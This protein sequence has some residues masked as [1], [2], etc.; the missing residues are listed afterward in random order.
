MNALR[1]ASELKAL[2]TTKASGSSSG[3]SKPVLF[4]IQPDFSIEVVSA[5]KV[6]PDPQVRRKMG[7]KNF[8]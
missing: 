3:G 4:A 8:Q 7:P 1:I 5:P 2:L 6:A